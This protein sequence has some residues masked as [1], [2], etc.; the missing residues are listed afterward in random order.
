MSRLPQSKTHEGGYSGHFC[1]DSRDV[2]IR[3]QD[4]LSRLFWAANTAQGYRPGP[5][6]TRPRMKLFTYST[7]YN[8]RRVKCRNLQD[9]QYQVVSPKFCFTSVIQIGL[10][11]ASGR[12]VPC[13]NSGQATVLSVT[14]FKKVNLPAPGNLNTRDLGLQE[15]GTSNRRTRPKRT[16]K[17]EMCS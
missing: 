11:K 15:I 4:S 6:S 14:S 1:S 7:N 2:N 5:A 17:Q 12:Y 9:Q 3:G 16:V 13:R 10:C 8:P